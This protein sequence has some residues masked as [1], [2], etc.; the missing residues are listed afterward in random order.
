MPRN[1]AEYGGPEE[2]EEYDENEDTQDWQGAEGHDQLYGAN[3]LLRGA[4]AALTQHVLERWKELAGDSSFRGDPDITSTGFTTLVLMPML[5]QDLA[6]GLKYEEHAAGDGEAGYRRDLEGLTGEPM[7]HLQASFARM[8]RERMD[9]ITLDNARSPEELAKAIGEHLPAIDAMA[10][11]L[12]AIND[13]LKD[14]AAEWADPPKYEPQVLWERSLE[15]NWDTVMELAENGL[16][17]EALAG[18]AAH[19][20][21]QAA[22]AFTRSQS[23]EEYLEAAQR[24]EEAE[25]PRAAMLREAMGDIKTALECA[26]SLGNLT[27]EN[28]N[29][30]GED[31]SVLWGPRGQALNDMSRELQDEL[32]GSLSDREM[33]LYDRTLRSLA[34]AD[35]TLIAIHNRPD[36]K[37]QPVT[38]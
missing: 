4:P 12:N 26:Q 13:E 29:P 6:A 31:G 27:Q 22:R 18:H 19:L 28:R 21:D 35:F 24:R 11:Y 8:V 32:G 3:A 33:A 15:G 34:H 16:R 37:R 17:P 10:E 1:T 20:L 30:G 36:E 23:G 9:L 25:G 14:T 2:Y 7:S 5:D 38:D